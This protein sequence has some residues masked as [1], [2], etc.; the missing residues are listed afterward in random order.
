MAVNEVTTLN[1]GDA[2]QIYYTDGI[3]NQIN[4]SF[5]DMEVLKKMRI[6]SPLARS[7]NWMISSDLGIAATGF[8]NVGTTNRSYLAAQQAS[9]AEKSAALREIGATIE[10]EQTLMKRIAGSPNHRYFNVMEEE[11]RKKRL[12]MMKR[13]CVAL[14]SDGTGVLGTI[15]S[16]NVD[17]LVAGKAVVTLK[18]GNTDR[19]HVGNFEMNDKVNHFAAAGTAGT[20][21]T[22]AAGTF[23]YWLV[24]DKDRDNNT[25]TLAPVN[26]LGVT[27]TTSA[28]APAAGEALYLDSQATIPNL[29]S[30]TD[31]GTETDN[32]VGLESWSADDSRAVFGVTMTGAT[33]G[34]RFN[35]Q[36]TPIDSSQ[37]QKAL[38]RVK[39]IAG[40]GAHVYDSLQMSPESEDALV[41]ALG[42]D[43]R[44]VSIADNT[45]G[46][47]G[48]FAYV[49][50]NSALKVHTSEYAP[51]NR[52]YSAPRGALEFHGT[53][54]SPI[55]MGNGS[56]FAPKP[57]SSGGHTN[58]QISYLQGFCQIV[59][60]KPSAI[61]VIHNFTNT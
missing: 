27:T 32:P 61:M 45:K 24:T 33:K 4:E 41:N 20:G 11:A 26:T 21:P 18:T 43:R 47:K 46:I 19:G 51:Q 30:I 59:C 53:D 2:L 16:V 38:S 34:S 8:L 60:T 22:I 6:K 13:L 55:D 7:I 56:I 15:S 58:M 50:R 23:D 44:F 17:S 54:I 42:A 37:L 36:G 35:G 28:W 10:L 9:S 52:V 48:G 57:S 25:V 29:S 49:H 12:G 39:T 31:Y 14:Y 3:F 5:E 1:H 40:E